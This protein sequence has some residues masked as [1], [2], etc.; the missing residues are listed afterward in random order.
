[1]KPETIQSIKQLEASTRVLTKGLRSNLTP[2]YHKR[3]KKILEQTPTALMDVYS[4]HKKLLELLRED[5]Y[6]IRGC[7]SDEERNARREAYRKN[8]THRVAK[9]YSSLYRTIDRFRK[10]NPN[11]VLPEHT[12][13]FVLE[14]F[15]IDYI[16][17]IIDEIDTDKLELARYLYLR[18]LD[19]NIDQHRPT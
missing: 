13:Q 8:M 2:Y 10:D 9:R 4:Y 16:S 12:D 7:L 6:I 18:I 15:R 17:T 19:T 1:M 11:E 3:K 14:Y 5:N